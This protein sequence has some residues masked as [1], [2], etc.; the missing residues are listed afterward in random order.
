VFV[1]TA[2]KAAREGKTTAEFLE[3]LLKIP[4]KEIQNYLQGTYGH[5]LMDIRADKMAISVRATLITAVSVFDILKD[6]GEQNFSIGNWVRSPGGGILF[7]SCTPAQRAAV[8]PLIT[9]WLAIA[10]ES[11]LQIT[12][13]ERRT[14]FLI[15]ELHNLKKLPRLDIS[16]AEVRKFG[17]CFVMGTQMISQLNSIYGHETAKTL[18]GLCGTKVVMRIPEPITANY[19]SDFLGEKEEAV[20]TEAISYGAN[21]VR[22]GVNISRHNTKKPGVPPAEIMDLKTGEAFIK[23]AGVDLTAGVQ[24]KLHD[25]REKEAKAF[26]DQCAQ[27]PAAP[28]IISLQE[29]LRRHPAAETDLK[30]CKIPLNDT[31]TSK[32]IYFFDEGTAMIGKFL[33]DARALNK[34]VVLFEDGSKYCDA[35]FEQ[36]KDILLNPKRGGCAWDMLAEFGGD[37]L[38]LVKVLIDLSDISD[39]DRSIAEDYLLTAFSN[40]DRI[41]TEIT[42]AA[43][44]D[45]LLFRSF[46]SILADFTGK[47]GINDKNTLERYFR[48]RNYLS[49]RFVCLNPGNA[50]NPEISLRKYA[51][52]FQNEYVL[53]VSCFRDSGM[54]DLL[55][56]IVESETTGIIRIF[57]AQTPLP[58]FSSCIVDASENGGFFDRDGTIVASISEISKRKLKIFDDVSVPEHVTHLVGIRGTNEILLVA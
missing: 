58:K 5:S 50:G 17:G 7:L 25:R 44:F 42:T 33:E 55:R 16:L 28:K 29:Y 54:K 15:D 2:K 1:E 49:L 39:D 13:T 45:K 30:F 12:P 21:T 57:A 36:G 26:K 20:T 38:R 4:M 9:A 8:I 56:L 22:D 24:F 48:I 32:P 52:D 53:F 35:F 23:F 14:W 37:Y 43:V 11:L 3:I 47:F 31:L 19:M 40:L 51:E 34:R 46:A 10:A 18:A 6:S 41:V 27:T